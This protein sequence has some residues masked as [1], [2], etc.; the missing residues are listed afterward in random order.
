MKNNYTHCT[1]DMMKHG[2]KE[3]RKIAPAKH[4]LMLLRQFASAYHV[5]HELP[6][7]LYG[8]IIN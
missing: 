7:N 3:N 5:E 4:T 2:K 1:N 6:N 8:F